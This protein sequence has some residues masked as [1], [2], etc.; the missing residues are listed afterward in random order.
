VAALV[1]LSGLLGNESATADPETV[2]IDTYQRYTVAFSA[3]G[4]FGAAAVAGRANG[5]LTVCAQHVTD[6]EADPGRYT[7]CLLVDDE[8]DARHRVIGSYKKHPGSRKAFD[9]RG[10]A[11]DAGRCQ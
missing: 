6:G 5:A 7:L 2:A 3:P 11:K 8:R 1:V 10:A 9:C 4:E